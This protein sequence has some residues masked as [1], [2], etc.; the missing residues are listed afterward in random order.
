MERGLRCG[1]ARVCYSICRYLPTSLSRAKDRGGLCCP[2]FP[3]LLVTP[4]PRPPCKAEI[5]EVTRLLPK[6]TNRASQAKG[7]PSYNAVF[8]LIPFNRCHHSFLH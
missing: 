8:I 6:Q 1:R 4:R 2:A 5:E 3:R 7:G